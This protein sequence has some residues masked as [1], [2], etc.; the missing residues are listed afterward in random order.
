MN[1]QMQDGCN[2]LLNYY[3]LI[4]VTQFLKQLGRVVKVQKKQTGINIME[5]DGT[6]K[7]NLKNSTARSPSRTLQIIQTF[8]VV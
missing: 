1:T 3:T 5:V 7:I 6:Q 2:I 8:L 4:N